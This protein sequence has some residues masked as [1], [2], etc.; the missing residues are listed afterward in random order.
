MHNFGLVYREVV[1]G[2][3]RHH[4]RELAA[5]RT[6]TAFLRITNADLESCSVVRLDGVS[7]ALLAKYRLCELSIVVACE[8][9]G[10]ASPV[11]GM[12]ESMLDIGT[13]HTRRTHG[14]FET[15]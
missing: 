7:G 10:E 14:A 12:T 4:E 8:K 11:M 13:G 6:T 9:I 3:W 1:G 2:I 5:L 15:V